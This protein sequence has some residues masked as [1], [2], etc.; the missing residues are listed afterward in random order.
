MLS[1]KQGRGGTRAHLF[2][3]TQA[4]HRH[5]R[6]VHGPHGLCRS[7]LHAYWCCR[8]PWGVFVM[9]GQEDA[10]EEAHHDDAPEEEVDGEYYDGDGWVKK[11]NASRLRATSHVQGVDAFCSQ[12]RC[13]R[14]TIMARLCV[15]ACVH[16]CA[17]SKGLGV[18]ESQLTMLRYMLLGLGTLQ[19]RLVFM[20]CDKEGVRGA[21]SQEHDCICGGRAVPAHMRTFCMPSAPWPPLAPGCCL[22]WRGRLRGGGR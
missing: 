3:V 16:M 11:R 14:G 9:L 1:E 6:D 19:P 22:Q 21:Y 17:S 8:R 12:G 5:G 18:G 13:A 2:T 20:A 7:A 4:L 10:Q 15:V